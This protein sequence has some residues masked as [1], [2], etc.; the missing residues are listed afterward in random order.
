MAHIATFKET[1]G[2]PNQRI[3]FTDGV[4][5][6]EGSGV[7][8][9]RLLR[10]FDAKG[11][12]DWVSDEMRDWALRHFSGVGDAASAATPVTPH[13]GEKPIY[14]QPWFIVLAIAFVLFFM[15]TV[16]T[17]FGLIGAASYTEMTIG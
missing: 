12:L 7:L 11:E 14:T 17:V 15:C 8:D 3:V 13:A 1:S 5:T 16:C 6:I 9:P 2:Y 4:F 10:D